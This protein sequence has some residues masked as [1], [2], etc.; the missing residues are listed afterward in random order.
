MKQKWMIL[1][2]VLTVGALFAQAAPS[3]TN[4]AAVPGENAAATTQ[5]TTDAAAEPAQRPTTNRARTQT[6]PEDALI[7][8]R[9]GNY[10]RAIQVCLS[11]LGSDART[12]TQKLDSHVVLCWSLMKAGRY[13]DTIR[14][15]QEGL[16]LNV[17]DS[18]L[19]FT[20][21]EAA[22]SLK[23]YRQALDAFERYVRVAPTGDKLQY[24]YNYMGEIFLEW[25]ENHHA[26]AAFATSVNIDPNVSALW[27]NLGVA[28]ERVKDIKGAK[29][30]YRRALNLQS[31]NEKA[32]AGLARIE[33]T[34][35]AL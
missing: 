25:G 24:V 31:Y 2:L 10:D 17:N 16:K 34:G 18:R 33:K 12:R 23:D 7:L 9:Q 22:F 14:Y 35:A 28:K 13:R 20:M 26:V 6:P 19:I 5:P 27:A 1:M 29:E 32:K 11:E 15:A 8:F 30:A 4:E 3:P 21:G